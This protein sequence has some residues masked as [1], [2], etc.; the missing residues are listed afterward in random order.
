MLYC[1]VINNEILTA[2]RPLP[3]EIAEVDAALNNWYP[4][5]F[6][7]MPHHIDAECNII[8][9]II[10]LTWNF[11][12]TIVTGT[13]VIENKFQ[14]DIEATIT[15]LMHLLREE[16]NKKL[17]LSDWTQLPVNPLTAE[18]KVLWE[19]YRQELRDLPDNT[20]DI[21]NVIWPTPP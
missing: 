11:D 18:Q 12:G 1:N 21:D 20:I 3:Q 10:K 15:L 19:T 5:V 13:H 16:R 9:Q 8:T 14:S 4:A 17:L 2:A 7:N 6:S